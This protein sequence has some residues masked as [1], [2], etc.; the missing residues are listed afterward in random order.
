MNGRETCKSMKNVIDFYERDSI[1]ILFANSVHNFPLHSHESFCIG[2]VEE[3]EVSFTIG[4]KQRMLHAGMIYIIPPNVG[5]A[6]RAE[7]RYRYIA[8]CLKNEWKEQL[9]NLEVY[10][11]FLE[12]PSSTMVHKMCTDYIEDGLSQKFVER[13]KNVIMP[14]ITEQINQGIVKGK[15]E[16]V[17]AA[18]RYIKDHVHEKFSLDVLAEAIHVSKFYLVKLFKKEM[19]VTPNQYYFQVKM[20]LVKK[21]IMD[22]E[23]EVDLAID[24]NFNDQSH[25][26]NLFKKQM[27]ITPQDYKKNFKRL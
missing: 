26:C 14:V 13:I 11:Y 16:I 1:E 23:K 22:Y 5:V 7:K 21:G 20:H 27:G 9:K 17:E 25:L 8:I 19:G 10:N 18:S 4:G 24:L 6:I 12:L 15:S 3:G 2:I